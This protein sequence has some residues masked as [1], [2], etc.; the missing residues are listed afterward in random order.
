MIWQLL[1]VFIS[2]LVV[3]GF[4]Y[5][6]IRISRNRL[7]RWIIPVAAGLGMLGYQ[8]YYNY[9]WY[10]FKLG[11]LPERAI[12]LEEKRTS[13]FFRP[14]SYVY[15]AINYFTFIDGD[16]RV[17][18]EDGKRLVQYIFFEMHQEHL[19]RLESQYYAL[20]CTKAEQM[21]LTDEGAFEPP[22]II[23]SVDRSGLLYK[24]LCQ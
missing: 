9:A 13:D 18:E 17:F 16:T 2:G 15:P 5:L 14:W 6:L 3:G 7:P 10:D 23:E 22:Y 12:V 20:D 19:D 8:A 24:K 1:A 21:K 11:Q 4:A